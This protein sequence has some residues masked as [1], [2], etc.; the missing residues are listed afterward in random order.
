MF[1]VI[2]FIP[3]FIAHFYFK[4]STLSWQ[5]LVFNWFMWCVETRVLPTLTRF[6][7]LGHIDTQKIQQCTIYLS[8]TCFYPLTHKL[9][10]S[11]FSPNDSSVYIIY[12]IY[13][14]LTNLCIQSV[15]HHLTI[16]V[17]YI[18]WRLSANFNQPCTL[19]NM[20][21]HHEKCMQLKGLFWLK[22]TH[23]LWNSLW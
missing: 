15:I 17:T 2:Y 1:S 23:H 11:P 16:I 4:K 5:C 21:K 7:V 22:I 19:E 8:F 6:V 3:G 20:S 10:F 18:S 12:Q 9:N 13:L 14:Y